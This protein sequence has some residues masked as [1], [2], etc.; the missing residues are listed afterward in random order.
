MIVPSGSSGRVGWPPLFRLIAW[1][2][3]W[4]VFDAPAANVPSDL[5]DQVVPA[6]SRSV[7]P[8]RL[9]DAVPVF[10]RVTV[11]FCR[12]SPAGFANIDVIRT[13]AAA[14]AGG[15]LPPPGSNHTGAVHARSAS[16][17]SLSWV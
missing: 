8:V 2:L 3:R 9:I 11:S 16:P 12:S 6:S 7:Q 13:L 14:L 1:P 17:C 10:F 15:G 5:N 4:M